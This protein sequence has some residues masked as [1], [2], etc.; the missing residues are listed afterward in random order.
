MSGTYQYGMPGLLI[1][2]I[3]IVFGTWLAYLGYKK[4][5]NQSINNYNYNILLVLG[6]IVVLYFIHLLYKNWGETW[7]YAFGLPNWLV[8]I[9]HVFN[10]IILIFVGCKV[11]DINKLVSMYFI[12]S[13]SLAALYH[14]HLMFIKH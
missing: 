3:H 7:Y 14:A 9:I 8:Q 2:I 13:G 12:V 5:T 10:G 6:I 11:L 4:I 1:H